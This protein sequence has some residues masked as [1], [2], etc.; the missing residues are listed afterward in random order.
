MVAIKQVHDQGQQHHIMVTGEFA[1]FVR[2]ELRIEGVSYEAPTPSALRGIIDSVFWHPG[3]LTQIESIEICKPIRMV[4]YRTNGINKIAGKNT[5]PLDVNDAR[6][7]MSQLILRDVAYGVKFRLCLNVASTETCNIPKYDTMMHRRL[8]LG[9]F[10]Y[11]PYLGRR[12]FPADIVLAS[13]ATLKPIPI[14]VD[15][16]AMFFDFYYEGDPK[17]SLYF[18]AKVENGVIRVPTR[19]EVIAH[20]LGLE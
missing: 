6:T 15:L 11:A 4:R 20:H 12:E 9:Q 1:N 5:Q 3:V 19:K 10:R 16:G 8:A 2:P 7:Q 14:S 17:I 18:D 13:D